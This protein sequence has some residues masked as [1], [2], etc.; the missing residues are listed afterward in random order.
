MNK[1]RFGYNSLPGKVNHITFNSL[2]AELDSVYANVNAF[3]VLEGQT[4][5]PMHKDW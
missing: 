1:R 4:G 3:L 2:K 5:E